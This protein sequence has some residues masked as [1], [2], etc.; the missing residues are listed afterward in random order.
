[1]E[2]ED[3]HTKLYYYFSHEIVREPHY[4]NAYQH[5]IYTINNGELKG[6]TFASL[7]GAKDAIKK[8][9]YGK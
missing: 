4:R 6:Q 1:M 8:A 9:R 3:W 7:Q 5:Y 2:R